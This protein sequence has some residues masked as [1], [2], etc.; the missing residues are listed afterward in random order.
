VIV[1][2]DPLPTLQEAIE[3]DVFTETSF[4]DDED[5]EKSK[6]NYSL[7]NSKVSS[8]RGQHALNVE[9]SKRPAEAMHKHEL[10]R[11]AKPTWARRFMK[12][13]RGKDAGIAV[14]VAKR[15]KASKKLE[16][17][18]SRKMFRQYAHRTHLEMNYDDAFRLPSV[19]DTFRQQLSE[20]RSTAEDLLQ[21]LPTSTTAA[22]EG[23]GLEGALE[24]LFRII[25]QDSTSLLKLLHNS[26]D[27][28]NMDILDDVKMEDRLSMWRQLITRAQLELPELKHSAAQFLS[29]VQS[30]DAEDVQ[31]ALRDPE[32]GLKK[33]RGHSITEVT[34]SL[35][36]QID[37]MM[38]RLQTAS[39]SLTSNMALLDS[40]RSIAEAQAVTK[41]TELAFFFIP[42]GFAATLF[43]MQIE[44]FENRAPL[45]VFVVIGLGFVAAS[46]LVRLI[47]RSTWLRNMIRASKASI[48]VYADSKRIPVQRGSV[49]ASLFIRWTAYEVNGIV[50]AAASAVWRFLTE[51]SPRMFS[52]LWESLDF[53][54]TMSLVI[55]VPAAAPIA[56]LWTR[57][58]DH[59]VK[60]MITIVILICIIGIFGVP[61]WRY[62]DPYVR[63]AIPSLLKRK[64]RV[65]RGTTSRTQVLFVVLCAIA[66]G[67]ILL[68]VI[69]TRPISPG[70]RAAV[71]VFIV[72]IVILSAI[73]WGIYRLVSIARI[74]ESSTSS[75]ASSGSRSLVSD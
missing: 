41:L 43:G 51:A 68:S 26:L 52:K 11:D 10:V 37:N 15:I 75:D 32:N 72:L 8:R 3:K 18:R 28:I 1:L 16:R 30:L 63:S 29:F 49:P 53:V 46:Y 50:R 17:I 27:A 2:L 6:S 24:P 65:F 64:L 25:Y 20:T 69:W 54:V 5:F 33:T 47:I 34:Q 22:N 14:D 45:W 66:I 70:I 40:R 36:R 44:Q 35:C 23:V 12:R 58:I 57:N 59:G 48:K 61:Y 19:M 7:E 71:T 13:I 42:L 60:I 38:Q 55:S 62:T 4:V 21:G 73:G 9:E 74:G 67:I 39:S 31:P 56:V